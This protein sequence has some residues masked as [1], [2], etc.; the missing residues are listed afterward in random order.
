MT[1]RNDSPW[2]IDGRSGATA[3][4]ADL[5]AVLN[6]SP[7]RV[8]PLCQPG[9]PRDAL[10]EIAAAVAFGTSLTLFDSDFGEREL[11]SLGHGNSPINHPVAVSGKGEAVTV[12]ALQELAAGKSPAR[13]GLFTSGSNGLPK[14]VVHPVGNLARTVKVSNRHRQDVWGFAYNPTHM[15]GI[16]VY[17]Q[18]LAN[19]CPVVDVFGLGREDVL[20]AIERHGITH[21]SA[22][23]S[24]Y[25]LLLPVDR[26][27]P[28]VRSITLGGENA[29]AV[30]LER[31]HPLFPAARFHNIYAST[32][33]GAL[34]TS[35]GDAFSIGAG[36]E[37]LVVLREGR[38]HIHR[39]LLGVFAGAAL[40]GEWYDTGDVVEVVS[41]EPLRFRIVARERDWVNVGGNKVNPCEVEAILEEFPG[42]RKVRVSG[43]ANSVMGYIL[44]A[45]IECSGPSPTESALRA[46]AAT[47]LQPFKIP[48]LIR[49]VDRIAHTRTGKVSRQ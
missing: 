12:Q 48:R 39:S 41:S 19:G 9:S 3:T 16:L 6:Q 20:A 37:Q 5:L 44:C 34:L 13:L 18:A 36:L 35:E 33:A 22:T 24:F 15:A 21:L 47:R 29:D 26:A 40:E 27:M 1:D 46:F 8:R 14:L 25:R 7:V 43:R 10:K 4:Y 38:I 23:P 30:L 45:E 42:V 31:L 2:F 28:G 49:F 32:E 17:L 11:E